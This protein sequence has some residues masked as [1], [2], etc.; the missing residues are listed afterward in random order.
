MSYCIF[1][2]FI[3]RLGYGIQGIDR[4][5]TSGELCSGLGGDDDFTK[6]DETVFR[7]KMGSISSSYNVKAMSWKNYVDMNDA[8]SGFIC[9]K[10]GTDS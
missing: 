3:F 4:A 6:E 5:H 10:E 9:E 1:E 7:L 2:I 8:E